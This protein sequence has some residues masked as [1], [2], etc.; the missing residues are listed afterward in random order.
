MTGSGSFAVDAPV[1]RVEAEARSVNHRFLKTTLRAHGPV[2]NVEAAVEES[3]RRHAE[4]GH[5]TVT[6]R[7]VPT[8]GQG[9]PPAIDERAF[10]SAADRLRSLAKA[11]GLGPVQAADVLAVP[12]VVL[13]AAGR[14]EDEPVAEACVRAAE[15]AL[16]ALAAS[17]GRE[18]VLLARELALLLS[19]VESA[20]KA[21]EA[22]APEVPAA[23]QARLLARLKE[24]LEPTGVAPDPAQVAREAALM[25]ERADVREEVARLLAHGEHGRQVLR[26][27]GPVGRRLDFLVQEMHREANTIGSK[28]G[29]LD[30]VRLVMDLKADVERLREQVQN[31]E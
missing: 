19:R 5:V 9:A 27:G 29:D 30:L 14:G 26:E 23:W 22:R 7:F 1:G 4:R 12:G 31:L 3:V 25:A 17:R 11:H 6:L 28:A 2:P 8:P 16:A 18:G 24:L 13:E 15:G 20:A 21:I 10:A